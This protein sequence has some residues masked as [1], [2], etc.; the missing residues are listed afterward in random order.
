MPSLILFLLW[1]GLL[2]LAGWIA[3]RKGLSAENYVAIGVVFSL[4][5]G[6]Y[7]FYE[8]SRATPGLDPDPG[9]GWPFLLAGPLP[10]IVL[11]AVMGARNRKRCPA[12]AETVHAE[13]KICR[14][15]RYDFSAGEPKAVSG[16]E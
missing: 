6:I 8:Y 15:C 14:Y 16:R 9:S 11:A 7:W 1:I 5:L 4:L 3:R 2:A 10:A 12:C 13:A